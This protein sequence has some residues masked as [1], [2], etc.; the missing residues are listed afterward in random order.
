MT[1]DL[2]RLSRGRRN[3]LAQSETYQIFLDWSCDTHELK[4]RSYVDRN[5]RFLT[6]LMAVKKIWAPTVRG[7]KKVGTVAQILA[8]KALIEAELPQL[9]FDF[10]SLHMKSTDLLRELRFQL[11]PFFRD[12]VSPQC[13]VDTSIVM[14]ILMI[15]NRRFFDRLFKTGLTESDNCQQIIR[16]AKVLERILLGN[17]NWGE[18]NTYHF[19]SLEKE[20]NLPNC[21]SGFN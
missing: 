18:S 16:G 17:K 14:Y 11:N 20:T 21:E 12:T 6:R 2:R 8:V 7:A 4:T 19:K 1:P 9:H 13:T 10:F 3:W 15:N 5:E